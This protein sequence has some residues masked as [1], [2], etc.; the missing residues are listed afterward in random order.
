MKVWMRKGYE[1]AKVVYGAGLGGGGGGAEGEGTERQRHET[2]PA[3]HAP[4]CSGKSS[5]KKYVTATTT[6][7]QERAEPRNPSSVWLTERLRPSDTGT[8]PF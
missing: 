7:G 3:G 2:A 5:Y 8:R 6:V 4:M 1:R